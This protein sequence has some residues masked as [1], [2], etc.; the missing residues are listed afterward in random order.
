MKRVDLILMV[1]GKKAFESNL[2]IK[3]QGENFFPWYIEGI[4]ELEE[5]KKEFSY[6]EI[7]IIYDSGV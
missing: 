3:Y 1:Y 6:V 5:L 4:E 7:E 2:V